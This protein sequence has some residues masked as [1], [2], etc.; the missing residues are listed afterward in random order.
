MQKFNATVNVTLKTLLRSVPF[1]LALAVLLGM[2]I[3]LASRPSYG[4]FD[5]DLEMTIWDTDPRF[6][7]SRTDYLQHVGNACVGQVMSLGMP[8]FSVVS[9][10]VVLFRNHGD[11]FFEVEKA[12]DLKASTY[13]YGRLAAL[14]LVNLVALIVACHLA[15]YWYV[16]TRGSVVGMTPLQIIQDSVPRIMRFVLLLNL[17]ATLFYIGFTYAIGSVFRSGYAAA[18][19]GLGHIVFYYYVSAYFRH[20]YAPI[21]FQYL[22]PT[23]RKLRY[24]L[25]ALDD[26]EGLGAEIYMQ[27]LDTS[28][29]DALI[30]IGALLGAAGIYCAVSYFLQRRR[31]L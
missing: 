21:Y 20:T 27:F 19:G 22:C 28:L 18:L 12:S 8:F 23:P 24:Y 4:T 1:Y 7:L 13:L 11:G 14:A 31:I 17:P 16:F 2:V 9:T 25:V 29:P 6:V 26:Q 10:L 15:F 5:F 3:Y 30:C